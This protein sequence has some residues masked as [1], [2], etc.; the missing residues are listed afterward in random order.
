MAGGGHNIIIIAQRELSKYIFAKR[1]LDPEGSEGY[2]AGMND[3]ESLS[4][5]DTVEI[6]HALMKS[7]PDIRLEEVSLG[8]IYRWTITLPG[9]DDDPG[10][11]NDEILLAILKEWFEE[12]NSL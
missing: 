4:W 12:V 11:A 10:L 2:N 8:M 5:E 9:F 7:H 1:E 3:Q 6:V